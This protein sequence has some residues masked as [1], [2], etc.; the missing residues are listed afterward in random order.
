MAYH[1][2]HT[3]SATDLP[4]RLLDGIKAVFSFIGMSLVAA[5]QANRRV[6]LVEQLSAKSDAELAEMGMRRE[7]IVR[8][9]FADVS[10]I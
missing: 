7:D 6:K 10:H 5:A 2:T 8:H 9:V 4:H 1:D 3:A